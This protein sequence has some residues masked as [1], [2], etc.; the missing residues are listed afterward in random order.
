M[1]CELGA[2]LSNFLLILIFLGLETK[3]C[4]FSWV[5]ASFESESV[6]E[7]SVG[8]AIFMVDSYNFLKHENKQFQVLLMK[9]KDE[10]LF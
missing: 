9:K 3:K 6:V 10:K 4:G 8:T 1:I 5:L 7:D 2:H